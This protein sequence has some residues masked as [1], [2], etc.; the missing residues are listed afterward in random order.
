MNI[1]IDIDD[2]IT[3]TYSVLLPMIAIKYGMDINKM[4]SQR[5]TYNF[6][7]KFG[8]S[9]LYCLTFSMHIIV[10]GNIFS[11]FAIDSPPD[12]RIEFTR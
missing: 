6:L 7:N 12:E 11:M 10:N 2:T 4:L 3:N 1:G 9:F 8:R 5:P